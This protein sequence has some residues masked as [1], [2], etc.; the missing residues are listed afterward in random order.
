MSIGFKV[1]PLWP[2]YD[3]LAPG[4]VSCD[5]RLYLFVNLSNKIKARAATLYWL[6]KRKLAKT[7]LSDH[8]A[9]CSTEGG[10]DFLFQEEFRALSTGERQ[11]AS[12]LYPSLDP[13]P[14]G[15][16]PAVQGSL[17]PVSLEN[18]EMWSGHHIPR[19][20]KPTNASELNHAGPSSES[21]KPRSLGHA[22][23]KAAFLSLPDFATL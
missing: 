12:P 5:Q 13:R 15:A 22:S 18:R 6:S 10:W 20:Q 19:L 2:S 1:L 8:S 14:N 17:D 11:E 7:L 4:T 9:F 21:R 23:S 16:A 3:G